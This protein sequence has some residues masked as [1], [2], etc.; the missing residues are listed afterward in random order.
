MSCLI[1]K[2]T[3]HEQ[4]HYQKIYVI[5]HLKLLYVLEMIFNIFCFNICHKN[6]LLMND[7]Y[8]ILSLTV[9]AVIRQKVWV[10]MWKVWHL[11]VFGT[12]FSLLF[13]ICF[14][15]AWYFLF[16]S[17]LMVSY[18]LRNNWRTNDWIL[19]W[20]FVDIVTQFHCIRCFVH[21]QCCTGRWIWRWWR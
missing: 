9:R 13:S 4:D 8:F 18:L 6:L 10:I 17:V 3:C 1:L 5:L 14:I 15:N 12:Q 20:I 16:F 19:V 2:W 7:N 11:N 21:M